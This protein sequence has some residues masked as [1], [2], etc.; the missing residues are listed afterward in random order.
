MPLTE[1]DRAAV[2]LLTLA[3]DGECHRYGTTGFDASES[4]RYEVLPPLSKPGR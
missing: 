4:F 3:G 2:A 1:L